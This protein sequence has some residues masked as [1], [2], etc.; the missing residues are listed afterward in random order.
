MEMDLHPMLTFGPWAATGE[1]QARWP[2]GY[3]C[4]GLV[5]VVG[6]VKFNQSICPENLL[7]IMNPSSGARSPDSCD[8]VDSLAYVGYFQPLVSPL[9]NER[10]IVSGN[11]L[12]GFA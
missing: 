11:D 3:C 1:P 10:R 9:E 12:A 2:A 7:S 4:S 8:L 5:G 6:R